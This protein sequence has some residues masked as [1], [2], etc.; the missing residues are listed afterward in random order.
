MP[1]FTEVRG[2]TNGFV[3]EGGADLPKMLASEQ[4]RMQRL[5]ELRLPHIAPLTDFVESLRDEMG[6]EAGIPYFDPWDGGIEAEVLFLLEAPGP[7]AVTTSFVS[8][9]NP[10]ET[11]KNFFELCEAAG[12]PRKKTVLWN[13]VP[14]YI[15]DGQRIRPATGIDVFEGSKPLRRLLSL[16]PNLKAVVFVGRKA[17]MASACINEIRPSLATLVCP[18]PSPM[19]INR[20]PE[21]KEQVLGSLR[22]VARVVS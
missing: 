21:N 12:L 16:L 1:S 6:A 10:D 5:Q 14:W 20:K 7:K 2:E 9:N 8:R 18:H 15:G 3:A 13:A 17:E 11:A 19:F 22:R 4:A